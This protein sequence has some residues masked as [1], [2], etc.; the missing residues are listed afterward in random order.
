[1]KVSKFMKSVLTFGVYLLRV[2]WG[3]AIIPSIPISFVSI[4][5]F[6]SP[7]SGESIFT[8]MMFLAMFPL[9]ISLLAA[10]VLSRHNVKMIFLPI[11]NIII[12]VIAYGGIQIIQQGRLTP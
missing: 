6:D 4:M 7:S 12:Y 3:L 5:L 2:L 1:M 11:I 9:P 10:I 8:Q